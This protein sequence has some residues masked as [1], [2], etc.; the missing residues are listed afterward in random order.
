MI[1]ELTKSKKSDFNTPSKLLFTEL[2]N[3]LSHNHFFD[4][5]Q[6]GFRSHHST[7][8]ALL[9]VENDILLSLV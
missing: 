7:E 1:V 3:F 9:K 6:S 5:L 2:H 8:F 4:T